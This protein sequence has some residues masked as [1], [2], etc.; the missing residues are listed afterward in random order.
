MT[1]IAS[2]VDEDGYEVCAVDS[3]L[4]DGLVT[5]GTVTLP[6]GVYYVKIE[7][8]MYGSEAPYYFRLVR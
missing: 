8:G 7:T 1:W 5:T 6:E 2:I 4:N 3:S